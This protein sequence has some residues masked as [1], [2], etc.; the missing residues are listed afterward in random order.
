MHQN[1]NRLR[2]AVH[3]NKYIA[4][5]DCINLFKSYCV[6]ISDYCS[7]VISFKKSQINLID[8]LT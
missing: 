1:I 4:P 6:S 2:T 8:R 3:C 5:N 7:F